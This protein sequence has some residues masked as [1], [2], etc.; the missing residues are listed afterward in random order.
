[1]LL[2]CGRQ[3]LPLRCVSYSSLRPDRCAV[4]VQVLLAF[5]RAEDVRVRQAGVQTIV[6]EKELL[7]VGVPE[8]G[9][10]VEVDL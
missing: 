7:G 1:M 2:R 5:A 9:E 8:V 6:Q 10:V 3:E 4:Q